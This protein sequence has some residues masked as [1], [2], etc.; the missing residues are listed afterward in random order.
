MINELDA[1]G[2]AMGSPIAHELGTILVV[3]DDPRMQRALQRMFS[4]EQSFDNSCDGHH[5]PGDDFG[6]FAGNSP[7]NAQSL[8]PQT[9]S[10]AFGSCSL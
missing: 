1:T 5:Y 10:S 7:D 9:Y 3:E 6:Y 2:E 8:L 4:A